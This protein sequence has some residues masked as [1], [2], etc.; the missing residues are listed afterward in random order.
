MTL[1]IRIH[2]VG[3]GQSI[4]AFTPNGKIVVI[5][6]GCSKDFSPLNWLSAYSKKIDSLI[7]THPH[8]DHIDEILLLKKFHIGQLWRPKWL[9]EQDIRKQNHSAYSV[10]KSN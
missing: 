7:I 6:L 4:H 9:E 10:L 5:D 1:N 8:G 3:H 2:N